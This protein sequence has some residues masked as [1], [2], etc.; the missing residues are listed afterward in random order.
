MANCLSGGYTAPNLD[1]AIIFPGSVTPHI[2]TQKTE[3]EK[4]KGTNTLPKRKINPNPDD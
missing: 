2:K 4:E 1:F 3:K